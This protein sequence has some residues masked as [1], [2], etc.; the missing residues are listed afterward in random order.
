MIDAILR[1]SLTNRFFVIA[2]AVVL[3]A[4]GIYD[5]RNVPVDVF[6]DLTAPTVTIL[7]EAHG[8]APEEVEKLVTIPIESALNGS[9][10]IRRVRSATSVGMALVWAE[11]DWGTD[12]LMA[13]QVVTEKLQLVQ[14]SLPPE[15]PPPVLAPISSI[16]GEILFVGLASKTASPT[17]LRTAADWVVRR[18]LL[19]VPGVAQVAT[20]GGLLQQ[21]QVVVRPADLIRHNVTIAEVV[22][23]IRA[24]NENTS[25]GFME[26][27]GQEY[28]IYGL[29]RPQSLEDIAN[30]V[31]HARD[32]VPLRV[33]DVADVVAGVAFRRGDA[34]VSGAPG[35]VLAVQKQPNVNTL[36]LSAQLDKVLVEIEKQLPDGMTLHS[37]LLRQ[38]D[39]IQASVENVSHALRDGA[40]LVILIVGA[41]LLSG[42]ATFITAVTIPI[43]L[44]VTVVVLRFLGISLNTMTMGGMAIAVG[45]LV[46][47]AIIDVENVVRRLRERARTQTETTTTLSIVFQAS[48]E[49]RGSIVFA[50]LIIVLVFV[51]LFFLEG[52]EGRLLQPLGWAYV[53]SLLASLVV[54]LT[55]TPA[56]CSLLLPTSR[57]VRK[58]TEP[59]L[60]RGLRRGYEHVLRNTIKVWPFWLVVSL[61]ATMVAGDVLTGAG[62]TFLPEFNEGALTVSVVT[63]PGTTLEESS[64]LAHR[65]ETMLLKHPE[66]VATARRTGRAELDEHSQPVSST[67]I[68]VRLT[69]TERS[70]GDFLSALRA[71]FAAVGGANIVIGQ[72]LSHRIDHMLSGTRAN[73]AVK[74]FGPQLAELNRLATKVEAEMAAIP[75]VVDLSIDQ[76]ANIPMVMVR[77]DRDALTHHQLR[78]RDVLETIETLFYG[79]PVSRVLSGP[80]AFDLVVRGP[81][82]STADLTKIRET[83]IPTPN[84]AWVPLELLADIHRDRGPGQI[85]RENG[86]RKMVV[87]ANVGA[88]YDLGGVVAAIQDRIRDKITVGPGYHIEYG[89]Q[90]EAA[91]DAAATLSILSVIVVIGIFLLLFVALKSVRDTWL[92]MVNLPLALIGGVAGVVASG[93]VVSIASM[94]GFV[95]LFGIATRN[96]IMLVTHIRHLVEQEG[97]TDSAQAVLRGASERLVPILMTALAS[98]LGLLPLAL[99]MGEPGSE[100]Q[101]PM[102]M[103]ILFGLASSTLLNMFVVPAL[104]LRFGSVSRRNAAVA[105]H[106]VG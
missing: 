44:V 30:A 80:Y 60:V 5:S 62:R 39:F 97:V 28:L 105:V 99:A 12:V 19:A 94:I 73:I 56:L 90:F 22:D 77:L 66:V 42:K 6:P 11:F 33:L 78:V 100:I 29:G 84:G 16:M 88:G 37:H 93:G 57:V 65:V 47:D 67:E 95:T 102:A 36:E 23:A 35:V 91:E 2:G 3:T 50:T 83:H 10:G 8:L 85:S 24:T 26:R 34:A 101:A 96:G 27:G 53:V 81:E 59:W 40:L 17:E 31:V 9:S 20:V 45:A 63:L 64:Q 55:V 25:A 41:F 61:S 58:G 13:R 21:F 14:S 75:G 7:T 15:L 51:P 68:E 32:R 48:K 18:R 106:N 79:T 74:I 82:D 52:V 43:S 4:W 46:D 104:T 103:V 49:I 54:A 69:W 71:D 86:E 72:P 70:E 89:G 98:G 92:V 87:M 1:W 38:A 76:Q